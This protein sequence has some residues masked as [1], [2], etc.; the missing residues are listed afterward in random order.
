MN[1]DELLKKAITHKA[2]LDTAKKDIANN[3]IM[4]QEL[5]TKVKELNKSIIDTKYISNYLDTLIKE[6]SNKF[7]KNL[8]GM[9]DYGVKTIF[10]D[11]EYSIEIRVQDNK[12]TIH[13]V[14][15]DENGNKLE[16]D[17]KNCGGGIRT[18]VG[19]LMQVAFITHYRLEPIMF[20]DEGLSQLSSQYI[21]NFMELIRMMAE[22]NSLKVVLITHD[23]RFIDY[24]TKH[25]EVKHGKATLIKGDTL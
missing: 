11:C 25:Y 19:Y 1:I 18:V 13:L 10:D 6:E 21:P 9:L 5:T 8:N 12:A 4:I 7:I 3:S 14:Y 24:A 23:D 2:V 20:I 16:P 17:I 15:D 22:K